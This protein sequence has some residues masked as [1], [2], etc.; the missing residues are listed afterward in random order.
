MYVCVRTGKLN[1]TI[2]FQ[3]MADKGIEAVR[4]GEMQIIPQRFE[5]TW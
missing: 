4:S 1:L 3:G 5:K 2:C